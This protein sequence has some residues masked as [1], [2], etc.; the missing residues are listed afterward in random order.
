VDVA[1]QR[2]SQTSA[3]REG[4]CGNRARVMDAGTGRA[5][6]SGLARP[7]LPLTASPSAWLMLPQHLAA[8]AVNRCGTVRPCMTECVCKK[9]SPAPP[10]AVGITFFLYL[11]SLSSARVCA[12]MNWEAAADRGCLQTL[13]AAVAGDPALP[14]W[15]PVRNLPTLGRYQSTYL[16]SIWRLEH[17]LRAGR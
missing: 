7:R 6:C 15:Q 5:R 12:L 14:A 11:T 16:C 3:R 4:R 10:S 8:W 17:R 13:R 1:G 2:G 9:P